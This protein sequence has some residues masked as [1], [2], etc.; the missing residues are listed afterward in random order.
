M[1][2]RKPKTRINGEGSIYKRQ[3]DGRW[4]GQYFDHTAVPP[5]YRYVYAKTQAEALQRLNEAMAKRGNGLAFDADRST[6]GEFLDRW[7]EDS[8]KDSVKPSTYENYSML[9]RC[10]LILALGRNQLKDLT[11]DHVR[12]FRSTKLKAGLSTRTV[13]LLLAL[14][15][16]ALQQA[17][18][19]GLVPRNVA[20][21][22]RVHQSQKRRG[23]VSDPERGQEVVVLGRRRPPGSHICVG[24]SHWAPPGRAIGPEMGG[25]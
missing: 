12:K 15:R 14:L 13:Q 5:K 8:V 25:H 22:I 18:N 17:V 21:D 9:T 23:T 20:Q 24:D 10:H 6:L 3:S 2:R 19:D 11:P 4:V 16:M 7:I 1:S